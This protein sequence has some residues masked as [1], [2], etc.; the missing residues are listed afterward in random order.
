MSEPGLFITCQGKLKP[1]TVDKEGGWLLDA[2]T[3]WSSTPYDSLHHGSYSTRAAADPDGEKSCRG[4][5]DSSSIKDQSCT[6]PVFE[7]RF[8]GEGE[9]S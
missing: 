1:T 6:A 7:E 5:A 8:Q 4:D 3:R 2:G 9:Y